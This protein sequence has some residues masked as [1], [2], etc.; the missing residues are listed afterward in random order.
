MKCVQL[1]GRLTRDLDAGHTA[2]GAAVTTFR[3]AVDRRAGK[4]ASFVA[5]KTSDRRAEPT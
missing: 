1:I 5:I 2:R 4:G 3:L